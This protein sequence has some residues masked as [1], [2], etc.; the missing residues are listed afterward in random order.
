MILKIIIFGWRGGGR[1]GRD[2]TVSI[3]TITAIIS[4]CMYCEINSNPAVS[5][6]YFF[7][8]SCHWLFHDIKKMMK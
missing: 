7:M 4:Q 3:T 6:I 5:T 8:I 2:I 1:Q